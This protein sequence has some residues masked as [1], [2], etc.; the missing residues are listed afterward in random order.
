MLAAD[1]SIRSSLAVKEVV[2]ELSADY[3]S[4]VIQEKCEAGH[5]RVD[6][7]SK[8]L[9]AAETQSR[10]FA[11]ECH[12]VAGSFAISE[13]TKP[14]VINLDFPALPSGNDRSQKV[15]ENGMEENAIQLC[16]KAAKFYQT[17]F[18]PLSLICS[19]RTNSLWSTLPR[20][21]TLLIKQA[22][23]RPSLMRWMLNSKRPCIWNSNETFRT[24]SVHLTAISHYPMGLCSNDISI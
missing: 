8:S 20:L 3:L 22:P 6:A 11:D 24:I 17:P 9:A 5:L 21:S 4:N 1:K 18:L 19:H 14:R 10:S 12:R 15:L 23:V 16:Y 2:G 7:S 13:D